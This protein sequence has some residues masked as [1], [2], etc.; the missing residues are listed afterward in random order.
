L[1]DLTTVWN[2]TAAAV[3]K[4]YVAS[5]ANNSLSNLN[6]AAGYTLPAVGPLPFDQIIK[7]DP[8]PDLNCQHM[9]EQISCD[10]AMEC[11]QSRDCNPNWDCPDCAWYD[12][13]CH[14]RKAGCEIDKARYRGQCELDKETARQA[15]EVTKATLKAQC[16][17]S[18]QAKFLGCELNQKWL[19]A[20]SGAEFG[21]VSGK[22]S[23]SPADVRVGISKISLPED[24]SGVSVHSSVSANANFTTSFNLQPYGAGYIACQVPWSGDVSF[25]VSVPAQTLNVSALVKPG[26]QA[27]G[28]VLPL[29]VTTAEQTLILKTSSP[30]I[31]ALLTQ[32]PSFVIKCFPATAALGVGVLFSQKL[33]EDLIKDTFR[34][35]VPAF[36]LPLSIQPIGLMLGGNA[37]ALVPSWGDRSL[38]F[39]ISKPK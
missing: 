39:T 11:S 27:A 13:G 5:L 17:V 36:H 30:P 22:A 28:G 3:S 6:F 9:A 4:K 10:I 33:R 15:C 38:Q 7:A 8:A 25:G 26:T 37:L 16:E 14:A 20:W 18:K 1:G 35:T 23:M 29:D 19:N 34:Y 31:L 21:D 32:N 24:L 12:V 2:G